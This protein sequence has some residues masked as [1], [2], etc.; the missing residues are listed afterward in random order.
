VER[1]ARWPLWLKGT[2]LTGTIVTFVVVAAVSGVIG[3]RAD[4]LFVSAFPILA[5]T[6]ALP[7][8]ELLLIVLLGWCLGMATA[9]FLTRDSP[10]QP[11]KSAT[12]V[13]EGLQQT[14]T[15][16]RT[17]Q[18]ELEAELTEVLQEIAQGHTAALPTILARLRYIF[19]RLGRTEDA[20]WCQAE[21]DGYDADTTPPYRYVEATLNWRSTG[22][23][24]VMNRMTGTIIGKPPE[25][26]ENIPLTAPVE[27]LVQLSRTGK[28]RATGRTQPGLTEAWREVVEVSPRAVQ[29][30]LRQ[31]LNETYRRAR[32]PQAPD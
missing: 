16:E 27:E 4:A 8:W 9:A 6:I 3:N 32:R 24:A 17:P 11:I 30:V 31:I 10:A 14:T 22:G 15:V 21:L 18:D 12:L 1:V 2:A 13:G 26:T 20:T 5:H 25:R 7:V 28:K 19:D 29:G 23:V